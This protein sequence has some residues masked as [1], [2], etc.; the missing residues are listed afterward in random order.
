MKSRLDFSRNPLKEQKQTWTPGATPW[1]TPGLPAGGTAP[2]TVWTTAAGDSQSM[3][4]KVAACH[5]LHQPYPAAQNQSSQPVLW[6]PAI[7]AMW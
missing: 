5:R 2:V 4:I 7:T 1:R 3:T 6:G